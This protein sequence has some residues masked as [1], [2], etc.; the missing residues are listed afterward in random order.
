MKTSTPNNVIRI[1]AT[2]L[3]LTSLQS[4]DVC[5]T[6]LECGLEMLDNWYYS[7][8]CKSGS[9]YSYSSSGGRS[10]SSSGGGRSHRPAYRPTN[11]NPQGNQ[12]TVIEKKIKTK[13]EKY[14]V[15][16]G[17]GLV[18]WSPEF[19]MID[20]WCKICQRNK[21]ATHQHPKKCKNCDGEGVIHVPIDKPI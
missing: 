19:Y 21:K 3:V 18:E 8:Q 9:G 13:K 4:C 20:N 15:C 11:N 14:T 17:K 6:L 2:L 5:G 7:N 12:E 1:I 16:N 10:Y